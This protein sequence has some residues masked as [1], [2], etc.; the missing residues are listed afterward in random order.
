MYW[1]AL[2]FA[3][4]TICVGLGYF[5]YQTISV[6]GCTYIST[7]HFGTY[8][9]HFGKPYSAILGWPFW[10]KLLTTLVH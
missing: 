4:H 1:I 2:N 5:W 3:A 7:D 10:Y 6:H 9:D 8:D